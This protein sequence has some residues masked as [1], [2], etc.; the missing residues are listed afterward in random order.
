M[1]T[2][3]NEDRIGLADRR[4]L[5]AG[6]VRDTGDQRHRQYLPGHMSHGPPHQTPSPSG[7]GHGAGTPAA[8]APYRS[9]LT[10]PAAGI[11]FSQSISSG[12]RTGWMTTFTK[13]QSPCQ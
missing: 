11:R 6:V 9:R 8:F 4:R 12:P 2:V 5:E 7:T 13:A 1:V 3:V 10:G